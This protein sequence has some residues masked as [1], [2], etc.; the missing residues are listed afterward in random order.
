VLVLV[1]VLLFVCVVGDGHASPGGPTA[2]GAIS[3]RTAAPLACHNRRLGQQ[4]QRRLCA[5]RAEAVSSCLVVLATGAGG[6]TRPRGPEKHMGSQSA[7]YLFIEPSSLARVAEYGLDRK[8]ASTLTCAA[9]A[10]ACDGRRSADS[11]AVDI[12][13]DFRDPATA[14]VWLFGTDRHI[15][16]PSSSLTPGASAICCCCCGS[17]VLVVSRPRVSIPS[18]RA[19]QTRTRTP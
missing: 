3:D 15:L 11:V 17:S 13:V 14:G 16:P 19:H 7:I 1:L 6:S 12:L 5:I 10:V 18:V 2:A 8:P 4:Q 9:A